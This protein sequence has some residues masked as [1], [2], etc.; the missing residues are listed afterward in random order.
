MSVEPK[1]IAALIEAFVSDEHASV[2]K[3]ENRELLDESSVWTLHQ[4]AADI[5]EAGFDEGTRTHEARERGRRQRKAD[6]DRTDKTAE[7]PS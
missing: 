5:Y 7:E 2:R 4:L 6:R 3:Y 1:E